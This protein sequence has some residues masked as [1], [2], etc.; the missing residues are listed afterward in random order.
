MSSLNCFPL[1]AA[2]AA[3]LAETAAVTVPE[4]AFRNIRNPFLLLHHGQ[5]CVASDTQFKLADLPTDEYNM[6]LQKKN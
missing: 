3:T 4:F 1:W 5:R 6:R 2:R